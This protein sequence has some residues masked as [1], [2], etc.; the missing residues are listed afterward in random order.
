MRPSVLLHAVA[1]SFVWLLAIAAGAQE[2]KVLN[3]YNWADYIGPTTLAEFEAETGI[4][5]NYDTYDSSETVEAKLLAGSTG[6]D[7]VFHSGEF[8]ARLIP[9]GVFRSLDRTR[10][11]NWRDLDPE[12]MGAMAGFDAGNLH[13]APYMWGSTGF[14]YDVERIRERLPD[15]PVE[16]AAMLFDPEVVKHFADC[17]VSL[18]GSASDV[19]PMALLHLGEDPNSTDPAVLARAV[20]VLQAVRPYIKY[21]GSNRM[22]TDLPNREVCVA[23]SWSGDYATARNRAT[24]AG[25]DIDL[26]YTVPAEGSLFWYDAMY[27]PA[28]APHP[29][30]AHLFIDFILRPKV[31]AAITNKVNYAN[32]VLTS[33]PYVT[34]EILR[35]PAV[36]A[37][38]A[39]LDRL[40]LTY[41]L[42]PKTE[43]LRTRAWARAK[44]GI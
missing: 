17:G 20:E 19:I 41:P 3:V 35:D 28:D 44:S 25:I 18:L 39:I 37:P 21:Y 23:M 40:Q 33:S 11:R 12:V 29:D 6:Y 32:A 27:V 22:L 36:Y 30:N 5:V 42:P 43:R 26:A 13:S 16:S 2:E 4:R 14:A 31:I 24:E 7:V 8:A 1:C 34:P 10:I 9:L 15:A 38:R